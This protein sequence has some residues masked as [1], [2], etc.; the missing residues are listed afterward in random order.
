[1]T[2]E[3]QIESFE[4]NPV[5]SLFKWAVILCL[6]GGVFTAFHYATLPAKKMI[7][8]QVLVNSHQYKEGMEQRAAILEANIAETQAMISTQPDNA[9]L[10]ATLASLKAQHRATLK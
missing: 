10:K 5:R 6:I 1:M 7:E 2:I 3:K 9:N 8:R 4:K